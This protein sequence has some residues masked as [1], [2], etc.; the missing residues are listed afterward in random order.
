M[1]LHTVNK[2]PTRSNTLSMCLQFIAASDAIVLLEDGVYG[3]M[4]TQ[5]SL[6]ASTT[7]P[8]YVIAADVK[9]RGIGD[10]LHTRVTV[11]DYL[12]FVE[13][14]THYDVVKTWS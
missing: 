2:S 7:H 4:D 14:C 9:A 11:I 8:V 3:A 10:R 6:I 1:I 12:R 13:L 5:Q